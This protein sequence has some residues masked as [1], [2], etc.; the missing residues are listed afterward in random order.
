MALID[1]YQNYTAP[2]KQTH[3]ITNNPALLK[4]VVERIQGKASSVERPIGDCTKLPNVDLVSEPHAGGALYRGR[5]KRWVSVDFV[6]VRRKRNAAM[7]IELTSSLD[8][9]DAGRLKHVI[10]FDVVWQVPHYPP[11]NSSGEGK[12]QF[13]E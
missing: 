3:K 13:Y 2:L 8:K 10:K 11:R 6:G 12:I 4:W 1:G 5:T 9:P 7:R